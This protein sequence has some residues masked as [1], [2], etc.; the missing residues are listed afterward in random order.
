MAELESDL[1]IQVAPLLVALGHIFAR[2]F[3]ISRDQLA[4][5][6]QKRLHRVSSRILH[7]GAALRKNFRTLQEISS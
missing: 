1:K 3:C 2:R 4:L 7:W 6:A 5:R